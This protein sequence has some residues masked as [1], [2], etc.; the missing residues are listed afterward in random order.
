MVQGSHRYTLPCLQIADRARLGENVELGESGCDF[1][2]LGNCLQV[3][4]FHHRLAHEGGWRIVGDP[5][6]LSGLTFISPHGRHITEHASALG[7]APALPTDR[8]ID[9]TTI[10]TATGGRLDLDHALTA[11]HSMLSR[12]NRN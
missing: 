4:T 9:P 5:A 2:R 3:C 11:L 12:P 10:A 6:E 1:S 7:A 8:R